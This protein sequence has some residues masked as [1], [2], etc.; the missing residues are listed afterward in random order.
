MEILYLLAEFW[1]FVQGMAMFENPKKV[2]KLTNF[3]HVK[4]GEPTKFYL[5]TARIMGII[6]MALAVFLFIAPFLFY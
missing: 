3:L 4:G 5:V 6:A 1:L 2:W